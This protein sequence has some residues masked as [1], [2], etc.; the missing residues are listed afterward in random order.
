MIIIES[1]TDMREWSR[2]QRSA[3]KTIGLVPTMGYLH[4]GHV[5][6]IAHAREK[7][8]VDHVVMS[9]FVNPTQFGPN[10]DFARYPR[11]I[12]R[13]KVIAERAGVD[14]VFIPEVGDIYPE[15]SSTFVEVDRLGSIMCGVSRPTHFRGVTTVVAKLFHITQ[16]HVAVFG[17]KDAQ[18]FLILRR[19]AHDLRMD[20]DMLMAPIVREQDGLAMSSRNIYLN[21]DERSQA[22]CLFESLEAARSMIHRGETSVPL[23]LSAMR[24]QLE[25]NSLVRIDYV[26]IRDLNTL[27]E[28]N[29]V[30]KPMLVALAAYV[31]KTRLIDNWIEG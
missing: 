14:V 28:L 27:D 21:P 19:M 1:S 22:L 6:L 11:D 25:R 9:I 31:G 30:R 13:D 15:N 4:D 20:I 24:K 16:P 23:V 18:Q 8:S 26:T 2:D 17:Q 10:E 7:G 12:E 29:T 3:G 5:S